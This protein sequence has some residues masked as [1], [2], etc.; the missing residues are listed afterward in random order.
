MA[1]ITT[2]VAHHILNSTPRVCEHFTFIA[3]TRFAHAGPLVIMLL[4][5]FR[6]STVTH[7]VTI[8]E[9]EFSGNVLFSGGSRVTGVE[10]YA[11]A[12]PITE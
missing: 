2:T 6:H 5:L 1:F 11:L 3:M 9:H 4:V 7:A 10:S 8:V 12:V